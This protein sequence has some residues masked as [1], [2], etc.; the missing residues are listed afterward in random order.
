MSVVMFFYKMT[1]DMGKKRKKKNYLFIVTS[2]PIE[3]IDVCIIKMIQYFTTMETLK[4][5]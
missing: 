4:C 3:E 1:D 2:T 5:L